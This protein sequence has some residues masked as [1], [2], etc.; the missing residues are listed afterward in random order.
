MQTIIQDLLRSE[1]KSDKIDFFFWVDKESC[2]CKTPPAGEDRPLKGSERKSEVTLKTIGPLPGHSSVH[3]ASLHLP[4]L[5]FLFPS[6][7]MF[8]DASAGC[9][10]ADDI[11]V[12]RL[13]H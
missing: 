1:R 13:G 10:G 11:Y 4:S 3:P 12:D 9:L 6:L 8:Q 7:H 5:L 2:L